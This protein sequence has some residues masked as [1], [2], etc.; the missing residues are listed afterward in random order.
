MASKDPYPDGCCLFCEMG[1]TAVKL[2]RQHV[3]MLKT[4]DQNDQT[5]SRR[6]VVC[7]AKVIK[8][9]VNT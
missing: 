8:S 3:H 9:T 2:K 7:T 4:V 1:M 5:V 6:L